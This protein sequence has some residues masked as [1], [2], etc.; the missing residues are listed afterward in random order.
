MAVSNEKLFRVLHAWLRANHGLTPVHLIIEVKEDHKPIEVDVA[1][2][3]HLR[4]L[5]KREEKAEKE[6]QIASIR[7]AEFKRKIL[8][9]LDRLEC[10]V[11]S[12]QLASEAGYEYGPYYRGCLK[13]L[14]DDGAIVRS[15]KGISKNQ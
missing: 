5:Q 14:A 7:L 2:R 15:K 13:A 4:R 10:P 6:A 1:S 12:K 3:A 8:A 9:A 11:P